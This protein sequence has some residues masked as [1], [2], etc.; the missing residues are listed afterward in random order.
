MKGSY[1]IGM[2]LES[3]IQTHGITGAKKYLAEIVGA[4]LAGTVIDLVVKG[5][6]SKAVTALGGKIGA[7]AGPIGIGAGI[8]AGWL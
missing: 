2:W 8:L 6:V 7:L 1:F 4:G 5:L 3:L